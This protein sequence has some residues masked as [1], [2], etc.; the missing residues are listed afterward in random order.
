MIHVLSLEQQH[1]ISVLIHILIIYKPGK[2]AIAL[3]LR[4]YFVAGT[5]PFRQMP[6]KYKWAVR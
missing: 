2:G 6:P 1:R 5:D 4:S 3:D